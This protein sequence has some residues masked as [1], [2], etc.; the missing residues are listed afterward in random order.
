[1]C[2]FNYVSFG[3]IPTGAS[4]RDLRGRFRGSPNLLKRLQAKAVMEFVDPRRGETILD[5]GCGAGFFAYE[6]SRRGAHGIGVDVVPVARGMTVG[7]GRVD[8]VRVDDGCQ[9]PFAAESLDKV[10]ISEVLTVLPAPERV[11]QESFRCLKPGGR[12]IVVNTVG[13][14]QIEEAFSRNGSSTLMSVCSR[15]FKRCPRSYE[16]FYTR[17]LQMDGVNR[18]RWFNR[19]E[20]EAVVRNAAFGDV[21]V[22]H[23]FKRLAFDVVSWMQ[24]GKLSMNRS[25][26]VDFGLLRYLILEAANALTSA[27]DRSNVIITGV[28]K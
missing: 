2:P 1:M 7:K 28:K 15:L 12:L 16:E 8:Y 6:L 25:I 11:A 26:Q 24:F 20:L 22:C 3:H 10:L 5:F 21:E 13:R 27:R 4:L 9:L 14:K 19:Q 23:P 17:L 18:P